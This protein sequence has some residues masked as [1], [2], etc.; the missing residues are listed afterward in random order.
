VQAMRFAFAGY[1]ILIL[2][3]A[4][5]IAALLRRSGRGRPW[6]M[7]ACTVGFVGVH[8][9]ALCVYTYGACNAWVDRHV[10]LLPADLR[11]TPEGGYAWHQARM[12]FKT[13]AASGAVLVTDDYLSA[14]GWQ[15]GVF[16]PDV[17]VREKRPE[18]CPYYRIVQVQNVDPMENVLFVTQDAPM[19]ALTRMECPG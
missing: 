12:Y 17:I 6:L 5:G 1:V 4:A 11:L 18:G 9:P 13:H 16:R 2:F 8:G 15:T 7:A 14:A 19:T 10:G 3:A